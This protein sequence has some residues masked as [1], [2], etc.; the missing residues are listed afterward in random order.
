MTGPQRQ[1]V[2]QLLADIA[3]GTLTLAVAPGTQSWHDV[4]AGNVLFDVSNGARLCIFNDCDEF[5]YVDQVT[6]PD[7]QTFG[8]H[9][10]YPR[11]LQAR[12]LDHDISDDDH[13]QLEHLF[14]RAK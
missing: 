13:E 1:A 14:R 6:L 9:D 8:Y 12:W 3:S 10:L 2:I 4:F 5:D 11:S 7:G